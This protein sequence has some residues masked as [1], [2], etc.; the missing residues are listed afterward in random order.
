MTTK[1]LL[2]DTRRAEL[3]TAAMELLRLY[4]VDGPPVPIE[5]ILR[6]PPGNLWQPDLSDLSLHSLP[7]TF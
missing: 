1:S 4:G 5:K 3:D 6:R 2:S 7:D